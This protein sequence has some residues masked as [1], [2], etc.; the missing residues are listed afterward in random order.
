VEISW[1]D[2]ASAKQVGADETYIAAAMY[3]QGG[4]MAVPSAAIVASPTQHAEAR[5]ARC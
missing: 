4:I 3:L 1:E 2:P 5:S